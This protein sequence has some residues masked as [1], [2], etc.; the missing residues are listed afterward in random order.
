MVAVIFA[1]EKCLNREEAKQEAAN[2]GCSFPELQG[3]RG[4]WDWGCTLVKS[5]RGSYEFAFLE[6]LCPRSSKVSN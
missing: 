4:C 1:A 2:Y 5:K 6:K 3:P